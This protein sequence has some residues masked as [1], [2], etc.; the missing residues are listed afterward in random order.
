MTKTIVNPAALAKPVGYSNGI[1]AHGGKILFLAGQTGMD[2]TGAIAA[3]G[4]IVAQF[5]QA[6][7]NLHAVVAD[8]GAQMTDIVKLNIFVVDKKAYQAHARE[9]GKAYREFFGKHYPSMTLVEVKS[10][11]DDDALLEIE[12]IAVVEG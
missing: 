8:A 10:L 4:D 12:G 3:P 9:I 11:Y 2:A 6:V 7:A 1:L 5:R